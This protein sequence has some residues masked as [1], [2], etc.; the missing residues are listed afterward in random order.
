MIVIFIIDL[1]IKTSQIVNNILSIEW[2]TSNNDVQTTM[3]I[4]YYNDM[5]HYHDGYLPSCLMNIFIQLL[6]GN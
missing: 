5:L 3:I 1:Y 6:Q 2:C 4:Y